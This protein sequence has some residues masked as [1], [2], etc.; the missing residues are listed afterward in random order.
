MQY[1]VW[2]GGMVIWSNSYYT[3]LMMTPIVLD[4]QMVICIIIERT[5]QGFELALMNV[6]TAHDFILEITKCM[7]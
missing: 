3:L 5:L 1:D 2:Q 4:N 6:W 7:S